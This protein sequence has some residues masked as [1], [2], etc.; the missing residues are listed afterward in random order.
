MGTWVPGPGRPVHG[1]GSR[2][3]H[4]PDA[5]STLWPLAPPGTGADR[6][7]GFLDLRQVSAP[8]GALEAGC[9]E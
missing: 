3:G 9:E 1:P 7:M 2:D 8:L 6:R 4:A 5:A